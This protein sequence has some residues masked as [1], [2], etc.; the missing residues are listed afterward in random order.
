VTVSVHFIMSGFGQA[1]GRPVQRRAVATLIIGAT[2]PHESSRTPKVPSACGFQGVTA[3]V[4]ILGSLADHMSS[5]RRSRVPT[6]SFE[7]SRLPCFVRGSLQVPYPHNFAVRLGFAV[8]SPCRSEFRLAIPCGSL[9]AAE[10]TFR[11][12]TVAI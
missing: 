12:P 6:M 4:G 3:A 11:P 10:Q 5:A 1:S 7:L 8:G 9:I 2:C